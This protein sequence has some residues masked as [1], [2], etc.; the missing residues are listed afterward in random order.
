MNVINGM[1]KYG[2]TSE[3]FILNETYRYIVMLL[4]VTTSLR[5]FVEDEIFDDEVCL[6]NCL[7]AIIYKIVLILLYNLTLTEM[8]TANNKL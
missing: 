1:E 2:G 7:E 6:E 4:L 8:P 5:N 3:H